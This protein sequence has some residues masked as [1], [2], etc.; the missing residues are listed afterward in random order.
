M[1][2]FP[3]PYASIRPLIETALAEDLGDAGDITTLATIAD[4]VTATAHINARKAGTVSGV[5]VAEMVFHHVDASLAVAITKRDG[6]RLAP[7][8]TIMTVI[9]NARS[10][11]TAERPALN[12]LGHMSG[13]ATATRHLVD[14]VEGT[15]A[16]I[17]CTRKTL[18]GLRA[19]QKFA[20]KCGGGMNHRFGLHDAVMIKDNH[21]VAAGGI[22][23]ALRAAKTSV[24]H[25]VKIEIEVDTIAQ[26]E[27]VLAEGADIILLDNMGPEMLRTAVAL[28]QGQAIL[29]AS[30]N[31]RAETVRAIAET[32]VDIISSGS[33][34]HSAPNL[35][36][37]LDLTL[38]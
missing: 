34:T 33:L 24:G 29:E 8:D 5:A 15:E 31:V 37:G 1:T 18:P 12:L 9:G 38:G 22:G 20:V 14:L 2:P 7:G 35:D 13:I 6:E 23:P 17:A 26:L 16:K 10:L 36:I 27:Q 28:A 3:L 30:G 4:D 32:G 11:L 21:I 25:T 19:L